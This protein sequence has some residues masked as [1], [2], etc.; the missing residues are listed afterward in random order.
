MEIQRLF[1]LCLEN[2]QDV[3]VGG[4]IV[5]W[6]V[7]FMIGVAKRL[8]LGNIRNKHLKRAILYFGSLSMVLPT[9][10]LYLM[11]EGVDFQY[12]WYAC[13]GVGIIMTV[14]YAFYENAG[15]RA[16]VHC[17]GEKTVGRV[18]KTLCLA[19][20]DKADGDDTIQ[21]LTMTTAELKEEVRRDLK[22]HVKEDRDLYDL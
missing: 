16:L 15:V 1:Q 3:L 4:V 10:A 7:I 5:A 9:T 13:I 12:Y 18:F 20:R 14:T 22:G 8:G 11:L 19:L 21:R 2:W 6:S 17:V